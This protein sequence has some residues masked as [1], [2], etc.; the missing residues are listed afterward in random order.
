MLL[1][2]QQE[3]NNELKNAVLERDLVL[4]KIQDSFSNAIQAS[5]LT[6]CLAE[7]P[8]AE[9]DELARLYLERPRRPH[10][11]EASARQQIFQRMRDE[12]ERTGVW[13][14]MNKNVSVARYTRSGDP[15]KIDCG[16]SAL[17]AV[18]MFHSLA[19]QSDVNSAKILAFSFPRLAE[20]I[21][22]EEKAQARLT[23]I[24]EDD[25][26]RTDDAISFALET[27]EQQQ[28]SVVP[29]SRMP[30]VA[31][32]TARVCRLF[33]ASRG[34]GRRR[35]PSPAK[36]AEVVACND[37]GALAVHDLRQRCLSAFFHI[38]PQRGLLGIIV[39]SPNPHALYTGLRHQIVYMYIL[40]L[41]R[42][43]DITYAQTSWLYAFINHPSAYALNLRRDWLAGRGGNVQHQS[44]FFR[45]IGAHA[46]FDLTN[47]AVP[48]QYGRIFLLHHGNALFFFHGKL[49]SAGA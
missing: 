9:A 46:A 12:F 29:L 25:L 39:A 18:K 1:A 31:A 7:Q 30:E 14:L 2:V 19:L 26:A 8:G 6:A 11:R 16:Y 34:R 37:L 43:L 33:R 13:S 45:I 49:G 35:L 28:I 47:G 15:L 42:T 10:S 21:A 4:R 32:T 27:L 40:H 24:V 5:D 20:G 23:A 17:G 22:R 48:H 3:L 41:G 38:D 44:A 36:S